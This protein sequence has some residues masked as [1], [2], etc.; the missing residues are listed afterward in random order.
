MSDIFIHGPNMIL[1]PGDFPYQHFY[2]ERSEIL[3][4]VIFL[5]YAALSC[6]EVVS[7]IRDSE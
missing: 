7:D 1:A 2:Y 3:C 6:L 5:F 4:S